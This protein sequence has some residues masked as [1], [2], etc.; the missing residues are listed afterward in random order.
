MKYIKMTKDPKLKFGYTGEKMLS[1][2][3]GLLFQK[4]LQLFRNNIK[5]IKVDWREGCCNLKLTRDF[6]LEE[7]ITQFNE[8]NIYK[9]VSTK[10][11]GIENQLQ[12]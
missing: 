3:S 2:Y 10:F 1:P 8:I 11:I 12:R 4:K 7:S 6:F 5:S 9:V